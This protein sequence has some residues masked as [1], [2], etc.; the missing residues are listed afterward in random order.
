FFYRERPRVPHR[1]GSVRVIVRRLREG[2][3]E[4][5]GVEGEPPG[6]ARRQHREEE[7]IVRR[8][9]PERPPQIELPEMNAA[10]CIE[11]VEQQRRDQKSGDDEEDAD[12]EV[13]DL[14]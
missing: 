2:V 13:A 4:V 9:D 14:E 8:K 5:A 10:G 3:G 7:R 1:P 6:G 12:A 11:L